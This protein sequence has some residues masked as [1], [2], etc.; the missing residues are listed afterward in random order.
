M[1]T[2]VVSSSESSLSRPR[3]QYLPTRIIGFLG[4]VALGDLHARDMMKFG[5]ILAD[6]GFGKIGVELH[7]E[8][9]RKIEEAD[10]GRV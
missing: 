1:E 6:H 8:R 10:V 4:K 5:R 9:V 2:T 7:Q 3:V